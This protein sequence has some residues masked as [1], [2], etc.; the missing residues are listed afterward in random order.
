[1]AIPPFPQ[2]LLASELDPV[3]PSRR[4]LFA[5][6]GLVLPLAAFTASPAAAATSNAL[7]SKSHTHHA[8]AAHKGKSHH[9]AVHTASHH[10]PHHSSHKVT[11]S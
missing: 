2:R 9:T 6:L 7:D 10:P 11:A 1:L 4:H 8:T 5:L 3:I